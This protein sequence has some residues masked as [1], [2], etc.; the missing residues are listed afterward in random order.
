MANFRNKYDPLRIFL[1]R[2]GTLALV[3]L[4]LAV[5]LGVWKVYQKERE[6]RTLR[7]Y[8]EVKRDELQ[9]REARLRDDTQRLKT[10]R[11]QEE[12]LREQFDVGMEGEGL[13]VIVEPP[14][15]EPIIVPPTFLE[16]VKSFFVWW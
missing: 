4:V 6:S 11:G 9:S 7:E 2:L 16:K 15:P 10:V 8:A 5:G 1:K 12:A 14:E 13:I 3:L